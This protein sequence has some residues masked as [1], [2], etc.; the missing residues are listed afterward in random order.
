MPAISTKKS[1][2][3]KEVKWKQKKKHGQE[4]KAQP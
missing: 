3:Q 1:S 2:K 4:K